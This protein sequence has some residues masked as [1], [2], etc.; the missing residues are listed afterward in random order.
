MAGQI[1][2][3]DKTKTQDW[4]GLVDVDLGAPIG[5]GVFTT[6]SFKHNDV[7]IDYHGI[8]L[9]LTRGVTIDTYC[10]EDKTNRNRNYIIEVSISH[11]IQFFSHQITL[12]RKFYVFSNLRNL[13]CSQ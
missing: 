6:K 8:E 9:R 5:R 1:E 11:F 7:V 3:L 13:R 2:L 4:R 12:V 10:M